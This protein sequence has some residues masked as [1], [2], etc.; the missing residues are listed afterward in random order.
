MERGEKEEMDRFQKMG[1]YKYCDRGEAMDDKEGKFVKVKW[2]RTNKGT[3][4]DP[5]VRCR[6]V[7]QELGFGEKMDELFAGTPSLTAVKMILSLMVSGVSMKRTVMILDVKCAFLY[8]RMRRTVYIELPHQDPKSKNGNLVG[9]LLKAMYGTRDAPLIWQGEVKATMTKIGFEA[10][11]LQPAVYYHR[12]RGLYV[13][14]HVDD[15][16][17]VGE[18]NDLD[19]LHSELAKEYDLKATKL[20]EGNE[21]SARYL[22]RT[23]RWTS[24]GLEIEGDSKHADILMKEWGMTECRGVDTPL[25]KDVEGELHHG[26]ELGE[27]EAKQV[28]R[29]IARI[30]Y[31]AQD[32]PDLSAASKVLS[33]GMSRPTTG[34][35]AGVKRVIRYLKHYPRC[36]N[37]FQYQESLSILVY[38]DSDWAGEVSSRRSTSGGFVLMGDHNVC[39]WSKLQSNLALS[40]GEAELNAAV[41]GIS[42]SIGVRELLEELTNMKV[43]M[44]LMTDANACKGMLLRHGTGK[45]KH[46]TTKQ[47]WCQGDVE[48]YGIRVIKFLGPRMLRTR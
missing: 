36:Y 45:V 42:E 3:A 21:T 29:G 43:D 31:M 37:L 47:L 6:L 30:N 15:F 16:L 35:L 5:V 18:E 9:R 28:R 22:N 17:C 20:G 13:V 11:V 44:S 34:S 40:S 10:S 46:L 48:N 19:W 41:K 38:T 23:L 7:A 12:A 14:A 27:A 8:G 24:I 1:V 26:E 2:V 32:R 33:Q 4:I 39:H 25:S